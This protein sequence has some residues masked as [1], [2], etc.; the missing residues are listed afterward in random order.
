MIFKLGKKAKDTVS[1]K[2]RE[3][4]TLSDPDAPRPDA[5]KNKPDGFVENAVA[6]ATGLSLVDAHYPGHDPIDYYGNGGFRF[7]DYSHQGSL[8]FLPSGTR[9]WDISSPEEFSEEAFTQVVAEADGIEIL[10][11]G[12]GNSLVPLH[13]EMKAKLREVGIICDVM[14]TGAAVRTLN[15]LLAEERAVA[16]AILAVD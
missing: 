2:A 4:S 9:R 10:L 11:I 16:A 6:M 8:M 15:I 3:K 5:A 1:D 12:S 14:D 7:G 13:P